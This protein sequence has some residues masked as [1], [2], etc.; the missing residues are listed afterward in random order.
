MSRVVEDDASMGALRWIAEIAVAHNVGNA[1]K[2]AY[3]YE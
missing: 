1:T 3:L 2:R